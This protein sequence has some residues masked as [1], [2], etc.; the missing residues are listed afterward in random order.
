LSARREFPKSQVTWGTSALVLSLLIVAELAPNFA[1]AQVGRPASVFRSPLQQIQS[2]TKIPILLPSK[3]PPIIIEKDIKLAMGEVKEDGY[4]ISLDYSDL[5]EVSA[6]AATFSGSTQKFGPDDLRNAGRVALSGGRTGW[7]RPV[8]CGGS[9]APANLWWEQNGVTYQIQI[10][11]RSDTTEKYQ[12]KI[13]VETAN[14]VVAVSSENSVTK[15]A[16]RFQPGVTW[17]SASVTN[18]DFTCRS[19]KQTGVLGESGEAVVVAVFLSGM[20]QEPEVLSFTLHRGFAT[21]ETD[22][23]NYDPMEDLGYS[24]PGFHRSKTCKGLSVDDRETD[25]VHLYWNH[26]SVRFDSW[27]N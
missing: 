24:L 27:R 23:L 9:C 13:L 25:P 2:Q 12:Q 8:S 17:K 20:D 14:S 26:Q 5:G 21:L 4:L 10:K 3:L 1:T 22:D 6:L 16:A 15:A 7:F 11:L 19:H 18:A